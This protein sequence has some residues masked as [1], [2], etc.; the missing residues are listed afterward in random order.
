[1]IYIYNYSVSVACS[2]VTERLGPPF[3]LIRYQNILLLIFMLVIISLRPHNY[4]Q[5]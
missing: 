3:R 4:A 1:M 5:I 2:R